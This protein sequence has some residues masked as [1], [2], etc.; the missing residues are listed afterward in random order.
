MIVHMDGA[1]FANA[2]VAQNVSAGG[3]SPGKPGVDVLSFGVIKNGGMN[4]E[5]VVFFDP[6][7]V[8]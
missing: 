6:T 5:A 1:R 8:A 3:I 4:A 7:R 2:L